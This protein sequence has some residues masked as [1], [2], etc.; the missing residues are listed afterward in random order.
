[1]ICQIIEYANPI[2]ICVNTATLEI[3]YLIAT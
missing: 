1:V 2:A 3:I